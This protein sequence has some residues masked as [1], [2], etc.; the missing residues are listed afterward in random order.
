MRAIHELIDRARRRIRVQAALEAATTATIGAS[1]GAGVVVV[2]MRIGAISHVIGAVALVVAP[3]VVA[4]V[5]IAAAARRP[6]ADAVAARL[7]RAS[8]LADRLATAIAFAG[9][10]EAGDRDSWRAAAIDDAIRAAPRARVEAATPYR[11]PR[12]ARAA[13]AYLIA[14]IVIA[15][16]VPAA[17]P[18]SEPRRLVLPAPDAEAAAPLGRDGSWDLGYPR[19]T[20]EHLRGLAI[21]RDA[22]MFVG[23]ADQLERQLDRLALGAIDRDE[24][25]ESLSKAERA[26]M[27]AAP[28]D[29]AVAIAAGDVREAIG[30]MVPGRKLARLGPPPVSV[31]LPPT[32]PPPPKA[33]PGPGGDAFGTGTAP[34]VGDPTP[35]NPDTTDVRVDEWRPEAT[36][37][38][39]STIRDAA[40]RGFASAPY[41]Q[42]YKDYAAIT[43]DVMHAENVPLS[44][45]YL[46]KRYFYSIR[47]E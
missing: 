46:V 3:V 20:V 45:R 12:H 43:D 28:V 37:A 39:R 18:P 38:I 32:A 31:P 10:H 19:D 42:V 17:I 8:G 4:A 23:L 33:K 34:L 40:R 13:A 14:A 22:P 24:L 11:V 21:Q 25:L 44:K 30:R 6:A 47:P 36:G 26:A 16:I 41:A 1:L 29:E 5:A 35:A 27:N 2:A 9:A 7:D 15:L